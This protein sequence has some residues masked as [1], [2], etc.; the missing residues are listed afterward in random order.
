MSATQQK[1]E[2]AYAQARM[3]QLSVDDRDNT[4][5]PTPSSSSTSLPTPTD[6]ITAEHALQAKEAGNTYYRNGDYPSALDQYT[7]AASSTHSAPDDLAIAFANR[8]AVYLKLE[9]YKETIANASRA[10]EL[11]PGYVKALLRRKEARVKL[12][13]FR[14][15]LD[16]AKELGD[17]AEVKRL[18]RMAEEKEKK[19]AKEAM[20]GLKELGNSILGNFGMSL[21]DFSVDKDPNT[22][23]YS[24]SMKQ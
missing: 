17:D 18:Q 12:R 4:S 8:A 7:R 22:G 9:L 10:L 13:E 15:A 24:V 1:S 3:G 16:D 6:T 11:K 19:D 14:A 20:D 21:N 5:A 2:A 23:S